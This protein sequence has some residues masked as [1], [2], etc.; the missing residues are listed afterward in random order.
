MITNLESLKPQFEI[1]EVLS[2]YL[3]LKKNGTNFACSCPF[4]SEKTASFMVNPKK[5]F[6]HCFGCEASGD[7]LKFVQ[8]YKNLNF[9][10]AVEEIARLL[11]LQVQKQEKRSDLGRLYAALNVLN[12]HFK[13]HLLRQENA[14]VLQY[15]HNRGLSGEAIDKYDI[16]LIP[17]G[18]PN[19]PPEVLHSAVEL[20]LCYANGVL[21][22][23]NRI[24][25]A[26]KNTSGKIVGFSNRTHPYGEFKNSAKYINSKDSKIFHKSEILYN[27]HNAK[28]AVFESGEVIITEGFLDSIALSILGATNAIATLG[29]AFNAT[30]LSQL[31]RLKGDLVLKIA[32]D[33]DKAGE[34][35]TLRALN[36][37]FK[38]QIFNA[39][40]LRL[41]G[42]AKDIGEVLETKAKE[43]KKLKS[44]AQDSI[45]SQPT[46][47][48]H[49]EHC[50]KSNETNRDP[51]VIQNNP[52]V[53]LSN[54][55]NLS[56][57]EKSST[58]IESQYF[59]SYHGLEFYLLTKLK[60]AKG[61]KDKDSIAK[62]AK[63]LLEAIPNY[64]QRQELINIAAQTL[65]I[66]NEYFTTKNY[67]NPNATPS[68]QSTKGK[69]NLESRLI[70]SI[71]TDK[72]CAYLAENYLFGEELSE[73]R[74]DYIKFID[75]KIWTPKAQEL[76]L[77][78]E[79][80][81]LSYQAFRLCLIEILKRHLRQQ[82]TRAK[83]KGDID[84]ILN[85]TTQLN[86]L[87]KG[88]L[89]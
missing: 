2:H 42:S 9:E 41:R 70:K 22:N 26:L 56:G 73:F 51:N 24:S 44:P 54:A 39:K 68:P 17:R 84:S 11:N 55:K 83:A 63:D 71:F 33:N 29:T 79:I 10:E 30:H 1:V 20:G 13:E 35:A 81:T 43:A 80:S 82:I 62:E 59:T 50:E 31:L 38:N 14:K 75:Q 61:I 45:E 16:G 3:P 34:E 69:D 40:V 66:P 27:L 32:F 88:Q 57:S 23:A 64:Y 65:E 53:I 25:F 74:E 58:S 85:L 72:N 47:H 8:A 28:A 77:N 19:L 36:L 78:D 37:C 67:R 46:P 52:N 15:L 86:A 49:F 60:E 18:K 89:C 12:K 87:A 21:N 76:L 4:H 5:Q 48:R 6:Y 7:A